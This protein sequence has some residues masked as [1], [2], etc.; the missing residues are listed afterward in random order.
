MNLLRI[1]F[2][3]IDMYD[4]ESILDV[5]LKSNLLRLGTIQWIGSLYNGQGKELCLTIQNHHSGS[6]SS[7]LPS[8]PSRSFHHVER[9][10]P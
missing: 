4:I 3:R 10:G 1:L 9:Q 7:A 8:L 5:L 6:T 2:N